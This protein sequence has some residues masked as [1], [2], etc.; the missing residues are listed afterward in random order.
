MVLVRT[1]TTSVG[2][3]IVRA[4]GVACDDLLWLIAAYDGVLRELWLIVAYFGVMTGGVSRCNRLPVF[5]SRC[6]SACE[7]VFFTH[8]TILR[9]SNALGTTRQIA[10][11]AKV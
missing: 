3:C 6:A 10:L 2:L 11:E 7:C 4:L 5:L 1:F 9:M 8:Q